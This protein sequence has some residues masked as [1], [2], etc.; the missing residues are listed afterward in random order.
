MDVTLE[1]RLE[2][3]SGVV[4]RDLD[5]EVV[6]LNLD[7]STYFGLDPVGSRMWSLIQ[8]HGSLSQVFE[9]L[10]KE[11]AVEAERLRTDLLALCGRFCASGLARVAA[12]EPSQV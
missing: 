12:S 7:S 6:I 2:I 9:I 8:E 11:Y 1:Q 3:P 5:G 4:S 10:Q